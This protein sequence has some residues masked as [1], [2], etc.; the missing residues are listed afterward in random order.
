MAGDALVI[1]L[2]VVGQVH[3]APGIDDAGAGALASV[4]T[5]SGETATLGDLARA[6]G[7]GSAPSAATGND[8]VVTPVA[9]RQ[10]LRCR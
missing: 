7:L 3:L 5:S 1:A 9:R 8:Q 6:L 10:R 2:P 4:F